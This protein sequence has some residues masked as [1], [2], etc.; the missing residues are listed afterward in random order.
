MAEQRKWQHVAYGWIARTPAPATIRKAKA[1]RKHRPTNGIYGG[2]EDAR[3]IGHLGELA[4]HG[5]LHDEAVA[6]VWD[7]GVNARPDFTI[8]NVSVGHK[9]GTIHVPLKPRH[10][11]TI[12]QEFLDDPVDVWAFTTYE[13]ETGRELIVGVIGRDE[14][15]Q[16]SWPSR[17]DVFGNDHDRARRHDLHVSQLYPPSLLLSMDNARVRELLGLNE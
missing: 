16:L 7:G 10:H 15:K 5:W 3:W 12:N 1:E 2:N 8:G 13:V 4:L 14:F 11:V 17:R 6:H 9:N